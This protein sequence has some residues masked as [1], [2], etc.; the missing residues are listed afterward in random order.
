M[1]STKNQNQSKIFKFK[2]KASPPETGGNA[3]HF[4]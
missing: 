2:Q 1:S 4:G 3:F